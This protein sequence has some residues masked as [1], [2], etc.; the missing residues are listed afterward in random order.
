MVI[1]HFQFIP[2]GPRVPVAGVV[3]AVALALGLL[4]TGSFIVRKARHRE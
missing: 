1:S 2:Q 4:G 3:G